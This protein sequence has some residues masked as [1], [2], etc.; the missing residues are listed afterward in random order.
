MRTT[1]GVG[2]VQPNDVEAKLILHRPHGHAHDSGTNM[3]S[4]RNECLTHRNQVAN[5]AFWLCSQKYKTLQ[6]QFYNT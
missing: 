1:F 6:L 4:R 5:V 3:K 2:S